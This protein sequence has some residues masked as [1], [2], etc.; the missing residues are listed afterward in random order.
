MPLTTVTEIPASGEMV[1]AAEPRGP[2]MTLPSGERKAE[3]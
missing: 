1:S 3:P 2:L